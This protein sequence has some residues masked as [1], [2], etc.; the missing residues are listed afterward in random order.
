MNFLT[1]F[2]IN[3]PAGK[4]VFNRDGKFAWRMSSTKGQMDSVRLV[5][6]YGEVIAEDVLR[7]FGWPNGSFKPYGQ[8]YEEVKETKKVEPAFVT[9]APIGGDFSILV[10]ANKV[11]WFTSKE[12]LNSYLEQQKQAEAPIVAVSLLRKGDTVYSVAPDGTPEIFK[13]QQGEK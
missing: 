4:L 11:L 7:N 6:P 13:K 2:W 1:K 9:E 3:T 8:V 12:D 10:K 5:I